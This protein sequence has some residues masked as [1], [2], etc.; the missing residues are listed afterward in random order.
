MQTNQPNINIQDTVSPPLWRIF[1][2]MFYDLW[3]VLAIWLIGV[4]IDTLIRHALT[5]SGYMG[6]HLL[7]QMYLV[8][9]PGFFYAWFWTHGGQ[10]LGMRSWR[11]RV[12]TAQ[13]KALNWR[14]A[15]TR[16]LGSVLSLAT[17]GLGYFWVLFSKDKMT[18]HDKLSHTR[19]VMMQK[20]K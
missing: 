12:I 9:S 16:Y 4:T 14:Q 2:S 7:L 11:I 19:L 20:R 5:G 17:F 13:G 18:W 8:I 6:N 1:A 15:S 3:L 10:T